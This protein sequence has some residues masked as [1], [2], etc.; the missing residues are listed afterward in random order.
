MSL[1]L[2]PWFS[3]LSPFLNIES[4]RIDILL[5]SLQVIIVAA[6]IIYSFA[7]LPG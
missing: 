3:K 6:W 4:A 2:A 7:A 5:K 1:F